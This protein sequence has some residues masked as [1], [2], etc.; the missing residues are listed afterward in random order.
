MNFIK[1]SEIFQNLLFLLGH[2]K[3]EINLEN[4]NLLNWRKSKGILFN[5][6]FDHQATFRESLFLPVYWA[7]GQ[8]GAE[9]YVHRQN[10]GEI[11]F[12]R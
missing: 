8:K 10:F 5:P 12:Y 7:K 2:T 4:T 9:L 3:Q 11:V 6:R 1:F